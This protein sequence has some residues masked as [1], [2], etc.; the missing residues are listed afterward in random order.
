M[1]SLCVEARLERA[2][3]NPGQPIA[4]DALLAYAE[5]LRRDLMQPSSPDEIEPLELP[6]ARSKC[7]RYWLASFSEQRVEERSRAH[8]VRRPLTT[9]IIDLG[10]DSIKTVHI[11]AGPN[12]GYRIPMEVG[13]LEG[14]LMRWWCIGDA[15]RIRSLLGHIHHLGR[16]RAV[17][18][19]KIKSWTVKPCEPW[20]E[21]F[22]VA[23]D[24]Q[25]LRNLPTDYPGITNPRLDYQPL[26]PPY[27]MRERAEEVFTP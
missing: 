20:G 1:E 12:K 17:G 27:W 6:L 5:A 8:I 23:R 9:D 2:I 11:G 26:T 22:P 25:A 18:R 13:H 4:L 7:G 14:D 3:V 10:D 19:G 24:G 16:R 15:E 21:G